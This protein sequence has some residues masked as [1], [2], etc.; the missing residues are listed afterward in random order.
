[1]GRLLLRKKVDDEHIEPA[2]VGLIG[3]STA[4]G[5][6]SSTAPEVSSI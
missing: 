4:V 5:F 1:M 6:S 3:R 2:A